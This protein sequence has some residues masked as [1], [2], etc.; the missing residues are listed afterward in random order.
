M[1]LDIPGENSRQ[2]HAGPLRRRGII[3]TL[4]DKENT[5]EKAS[6]YMAWVSTSEAPVERDT[7]EV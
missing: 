2:H 7:A 1:H 3:S 6:W 4:I 5:E